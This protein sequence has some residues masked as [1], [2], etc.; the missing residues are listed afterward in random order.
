MR[1]FHFTSLYTT[2]P[3]TIISQSRAAIGNPDFRPPHGKI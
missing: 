1:L 2:E 3:A